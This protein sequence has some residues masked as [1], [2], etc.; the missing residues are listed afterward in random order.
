MKRMLLTCTLAAICL[1]LAA[2]AFAGSLDN[3]RV[4]LHAKAWTAKNVCTT[5]APVGVPCNQYVTEWPIGVSSYTYV[6]IGKGQPESGGIAGIELGVLYDQAVGQFGWVLCADLEFTNAGQGG[7]WP[8]S[9]GGNRITWDAGTNCQVNDW[10]PD[11]LHA[12]CGAFYLYAYGN[13]IFQITPNNNVAVPGLTVAACDASAS[14][15]SP[16]AAGYVGFGTTQG[17]NPCDVVVATKPT[18]W[19]NIKSQYT[20]KSE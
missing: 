15:L 9:T 18:T 10:P 17:Y 3:A 19:G 7:E 16:L 4:S 14:A 11:D 8:A 6:I 5:W 1:C 2:A 13:G 12:I 20:D